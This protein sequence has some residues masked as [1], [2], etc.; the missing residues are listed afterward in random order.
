[1]ENL[2]FRTA[3]LEGGYRK[4]RQKGRTGLVRGWYGG[5][6]TDAVRTYGVGTG[7][8]RGLVRGFRTDF[9]RISYQ[10]FF[11][12]VQKNFF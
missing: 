7:L 6:R 4:I 12:W 5:S 2:A 11:W 1:M 10:N 8:V 9:V 3:G